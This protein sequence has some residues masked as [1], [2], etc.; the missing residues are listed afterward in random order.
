MIEFALDW[1]LYLV[2]FLGVGFLTLS[3]VFIWA[4]YHLIVSIH[5]RKKV[6]IAYFRIALVPAI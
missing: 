5:K 2:V 1:Y 4:L 6:F 3:S